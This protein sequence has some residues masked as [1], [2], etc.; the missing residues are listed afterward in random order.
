MAVTDA[1][2]DDVE[3]KMEAEDNAEQPEEPELRLPSIYPEPGTELVVIS[4]D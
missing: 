1:L 4:E 2:F 3:A